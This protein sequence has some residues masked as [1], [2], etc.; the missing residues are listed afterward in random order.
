[1]TG[2]GRSTRHSAISPT[3]LPISLEWC[4]TSALSRFPQFLYYFWCQFSPVVYLS[5]ACTCSFSVLF[6]SFLFI[7]LSP[8]S[9]KLLLFCFLHCFIYEI[10]CSMSD[11]L[12]S[13]SVTSDIS[14]L[15]FCTS[16]DDLI[17][18]L[19]TLGI[20][21]TVSRFYF[22]VQVHAVEYSWFPLQM[23]NRSRFCC[24]CC[25]CWLIVHDYPKCS[26]GNMMNAYR[27]L[28]LVVVIIQP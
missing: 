22:G 15:Q 20:Q 17:L 2:N 28:H 10:S 13:S 19:S 25:Q 24:Q 7:D 8:F 3:L 11:F 4:L 21:S 14:L 12:S 5:S 26:Q 23:V 1:V 27:S 6:L 16:C 9:I 18:C